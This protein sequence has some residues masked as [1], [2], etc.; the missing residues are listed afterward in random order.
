MDADIIF[1]GFPEKNKPEKPKKEAKAPAKKRINIKKKESKSKRIIPLIDKPLTL[2][3]HNAYQGIVSAIGF[4][5]IKHHN[6]TKF[7]EGECRL[8]LTLEYESHEKQDQ[9]KD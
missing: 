6:S 3:K 5:M 4:E 7:L 1:S 9:R 2:S 8:K